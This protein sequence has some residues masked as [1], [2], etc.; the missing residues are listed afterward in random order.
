MFIT[1]RLTWCFPNDVFPEIA[2]YSSS[3]LQDTVEGYE[4][5]LSLCSILL[6]FGGGGE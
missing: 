4:A 3:D 5:K 2:I 6:I 1:A